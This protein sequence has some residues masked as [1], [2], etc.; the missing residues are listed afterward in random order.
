LP[1]IKANE[2]YIRWIDESLGLKVIDFENDKS[3]KVKKD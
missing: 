2:E 3:I 1:I